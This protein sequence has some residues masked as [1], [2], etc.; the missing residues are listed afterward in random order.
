MMQILFVRHFTIHCS[1]L[2]WQT[3]LQV[4]LPNEKNNFWA[5]SCRAIGKRMWRETTMFDLLYANSRSSNHPVETTILYMDVSTSRYIPL[6]LFQKMMVLP[7]D[8]S[9]LSR[10]WGCHQPI[11]DWN[12]IYKTFTNITRQNAGEILE[13]KFKGDGG[14]KET[15]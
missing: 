9:K 5:A 13:S 15:P 2:A 11:T 3:Y 7:L 6:G 10:D 14:E 8:F 4:F 12:W 1:S